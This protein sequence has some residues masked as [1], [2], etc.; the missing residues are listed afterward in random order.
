[1]GSGS[2]LLT[3]RPPTYITTNPLRSLPPL[4]KVHHLCEGIDPVYLNGPFGGDSQCQYHPQSCHSNFTREDSWALL[5]DYARI[6][7]AFPAMRDAAGTFDTV[8]Q[9][10]V[11]ATKLHPTGRQPYLYLGESPWINLHDPR[12]TSLD[13]CQVQQTR[14]MMMNASDRLTAS[15]ERLGTD[16]YMGHVQFDVESWSWSPSYDTPGYSTPSGLAIMAA[17]KRK[18][19]LIYNVTRAV[20]PWTEKT[21][22]TILYFDYAHAFWIPTGS[23]DGCYNVQVGVVTACFTWVL[24]S[25]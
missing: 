5:V 8:V 3:N 18:N 10:C 9:I 1:M 21:P 7:G 23:T 24:H 22:T 16:I 6:T 20:F 17:I 15:N 12:N 13:D 14:E 25:R 4:P 19:E 11:N 2:A